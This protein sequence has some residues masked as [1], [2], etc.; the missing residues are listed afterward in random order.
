MYKITTGGNFYA[1]GKT[2]A[3]GAE[4]KEYAERL[5]K[6][7]RTFDVYKDGE[8]YATGDDTGIYPIRKARKRI[9]GSVGYAQMM[10]ERR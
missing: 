10:S 6:A 1:W 3:T 5:V 4:A 2:F 9:T 7:R 8:L